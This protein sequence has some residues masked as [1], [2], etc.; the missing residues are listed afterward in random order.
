[1]VRNGVE[2]DLQAKISEIGCGEVEVWI[3][4]GD[5][6]KGSR[7]WQGSPFAVWLGTHAEGARPLSLS[8]FRINTFGCPSAVVTCSVSHHIASHHIE[9]HRLF[10]TTAPPRPRTAPVLLPPLKPHT[11]RGKGSDYRS[12]PNS[13]AGDEHRLSMCRWKSEVNNYHIATTFLVH[14]SS[15]LDSTISASPHRC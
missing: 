13:K 3:S 11:S 9:G 12:N 4:I 15:N 5:S 10:L 14:T 7:L 1:M 2:R 6:P 8:R